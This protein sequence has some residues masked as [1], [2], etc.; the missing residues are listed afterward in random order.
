[1]PLLQI[2]SGGGELF[3]LP[4]PSPETV[5]NVAAA[6]ELMSAGEEENGRA[7]IVAELMPLFPRR[8]RKPLLELSRADAFELGLALLNEYAPRRPAGPLPEE[9]EVIAVAFGFKW[10]LEYAGALSPE[11]RRKCLDFLSGSRRERDAG[12]AT[13]S[14]E[15]VKKAAAR[16]AAAL[17]RFRRSGK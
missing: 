4:P 8:Y 13:V 2:L 9:D 10:S 14:A 5:G 17:E 15:E 1:M 7:R 3:E 12:T 6:L 16:G 11:R